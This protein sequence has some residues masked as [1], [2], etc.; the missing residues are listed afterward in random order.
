MAETKYLIIGNGVAAISALQEIRHADPS[1]SI[2]LVYDEGEPF[3]YRASLSEWISGKNSDDMVAGRTPEFYENMK[4]TQLHGRVERVDAEKHQAFLA[5]GET[6]AYQKLLVATGAQANRF[7]V[8]G[9]GEVL[10]FRTLADARSLKERA[11]SCRRALIVGGGILGLELAGGLHLLGIEHVA[12]AHLGPFV[13]PPLLDEPAAEW[14][15]ERMRADRIVL[16]LE[17][18]LDRVEGHMTYLRSG[19]TWECDTIIQAIGVTPVFPEV[20]GLLTGRGIRIDDHCRTNLPDVYAAG[21]CT[22]RQVP[23]SDVWRTTRIWLDCSWQGN[24]VGRNMAGGD[25]SLEAKP[26][27]NASVLYTFDYSYIGEPHGE[28]GE[29]YRWQ[30]KDGYCKVRVVDGKFAGALKIT[31][32]HGAMAMREAVGL[33]VEA[34]LATRMSHPDF[35]FNNV[36]GQDWDYLFY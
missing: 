8:K 14:L 13:G 17:D 22:E 2:L 16:Y 15:Q 21:D 4:I 28:E 7:P 10:V 29:A 24:T 19:R 30:G 1:G 32:R 23:G 34:D 31:D 36:T 33:P 26:F 5:D 18:T 6:I 27:F 25:D 12:I 9:L 35:Q 11:M 20:S 3:Y